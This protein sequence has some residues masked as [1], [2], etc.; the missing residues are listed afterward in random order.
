MIRTG[1]CDA[2]LESYE[3][4]LAIREAAL[5]NEHHKL[6]YSLN[7]MA[8]CEHKQGKTADAR[9]HFQ[10]V[11]SLLEGGELEPDQLEQAREGLAALGAG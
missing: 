9:E 1:D 4:A 6:T 8:E 5:G 3:T 11:V 10:R 2:A 7:G